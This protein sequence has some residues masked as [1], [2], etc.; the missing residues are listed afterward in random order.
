MFFYMLTTAHFKRGA[1]DFCA[2]GRASLT[3]KGGFDAH[4][5]EFKKVRFSKVIFEA[6]EWLLDTLLVG[7]IENQ[8]CIPPKGGIT[9]PCLLRRGRLP[10][11]FMGL[12]LVIKSSV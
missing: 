1:N 11:S 2:N 7:L 5:G 3:S 4:E 9:A 8:K 10:F 12:N 6:G